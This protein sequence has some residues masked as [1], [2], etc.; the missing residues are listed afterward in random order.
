CAAAA[1]NRPTRL[2]APPPNDQKNWHA[3]PRPCCSHAFLSRRAQR[4]RL[5]RPQQS[6]L[7]LSDT[8][9]LV[10]PS[11]SGN[12]LA[13]ECPA[14]EIYDLSTSRKFTRPHTAGMTRKRQ[15][16]RQNILAE[17]MHALPR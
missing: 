6:V 12:V 2:K 9:G 16:P 13:I 11:R 15:Q 4:H 5:L 7:L 17:P 3:S 14:R 1:Q 10:M 8:H